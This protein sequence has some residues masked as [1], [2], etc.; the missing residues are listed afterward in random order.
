MRAIAWIAEPDGDEYKYLDLERY[1]A[2]LRIAWGFDKTLVVDVSGTT[3]VKGQY[4]N[5]VYASWAALNEAYTDAA[6][7]CLVPGAPNL[8]DYVEPVG[9]VIYVLGGDYGEAHNFGVKPDA[10]ISVGTA[11]PQG[12]GTWSFLA[13]AVVASKLYNGT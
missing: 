6:Y 11:L 7:V 5:E 2:D 10:T 8:D 12:A 4:D 1:W 9:D 13:M 3:F